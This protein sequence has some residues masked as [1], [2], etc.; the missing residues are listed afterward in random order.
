VGAHLGGAVEGTSVALGE[1]GEELGMWCDVEKVRK[2]YKLGGGNAG[3]KGGKG[4]VVNGES[5]V[6]RRKAEEK[7]EIE[8]VVLG[9]IALKGS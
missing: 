8:S 5:D 6:E 7:K 1:T 2:M 3:K 9:V 4:G